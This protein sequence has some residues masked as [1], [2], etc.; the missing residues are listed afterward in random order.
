MTPGRGSQNVEKTQVDAMIQANEP[1]APDPV[2]ARPR[3]RFSAVPSAPKN[4][5]FEEPNLEG[6]R[7]A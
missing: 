2:P 7:F 3:R 4:G 6:A 5:I 1:N